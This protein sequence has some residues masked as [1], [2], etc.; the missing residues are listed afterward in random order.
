MVQ[1]ALYRP[2]VLIGP[3]PAS[4][5]ANLIRIQKQSIRGNT[6]KQNTNK[7]YTNNRNTN[8]KELYNQS[9]GH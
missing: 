1:Q 8:T 7:Q 3:P 2:G 4:V 9:R 5:S 6:N